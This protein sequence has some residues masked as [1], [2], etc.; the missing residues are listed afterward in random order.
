MI[1]ASVRLSSIQIKDFTFKPF[2][3]RFLSFIYFIFP[4]CQER[5]EYCK[6]LGGYL[7]FIYVTYGS[8]SFMALG[9]K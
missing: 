3:Y 2:S 1:G 4:V 7:S 6:G 9:L 8:S 5:N